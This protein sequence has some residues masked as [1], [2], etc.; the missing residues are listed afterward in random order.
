MKRYWEVDTLRGSAIIAMIVFHTAYILVFLKFL[1]FHLHSGFWWVF[2]RCIAGT[3]LL[4]V[5]I[6]LTLSYG[7]VKQTLSRIKIIQK[8]LLRG[9]LIFLLGFVLTFASFFMVG[10][11]R[12]VLFGV[13]HLIGTSIIL[14]IPL[15]SFKWIN[16]IAGSLVLGTGLILG[17]YRFDFFWFL[18][19]GFRPDN[20]YPVDYL[21]LFPWFSFVLFGMFIG[22]LCYKENKRVIPLPDIGDFFIIRG[23]CVLGRLSLYIYLAHIPVIY[24]ILLGVKL[25][26]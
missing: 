18:W 17:M 9:L 16:L 14:A 2:P 20:Y 8:Y 10:N 24:G 22:N 12:M 23:L 7:R 4:I 6:S 1:D 25:L 26:F 21:P 11:E 15:I 19:L 3:F 5:G 13:L